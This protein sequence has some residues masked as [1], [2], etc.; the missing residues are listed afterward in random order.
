M[1]NFND[2]L[3][4]LF[5]ILIMSHLLRCFRLKATQQIDPYDKLIPIIYI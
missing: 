1:S 3:F 4:V 2:V 5:L